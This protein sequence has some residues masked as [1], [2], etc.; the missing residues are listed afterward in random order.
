MATGSGIIRKVSGK[1][2][3]L[4][5][6][7]QNGQQVIAAYNPH[8]KNPQ[9]TLQMQQRTKWLNVLAMYK[10]MKPYLK[11]AF[12]NK[13]SGQ[14]D[15][16]RFMGINLQAVPVYLTRA[17]FV[18]GGAIIAPYLIAQ[19]SLPA[20]TMTGNTTDIVANFTDAATVAEASASILSGDARFKQGDALCFFVVA[21]SVSAEGTPVAQAYAMKLPLDLT[22][23]T[24]LSSLYTAQLGIVATDGL[25]SVTTNSEVYAT[26][27]VHTRRTEKLLVSSARLQVT[28]DINTLLSDST[29]AASANS[30]GYTEGDIFLEPDSTVPVTSNGSGSTD[31]TEEDDNTGSSGTGNNDSSGEDSNP[32]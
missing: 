29:F 25:V 21:Q 32:L 23:T 6:R 7:V 8:V 4:V 10:V 18:D 31:D 9:T 19:G 26:A 1:V 5:Y 22:D 24:P 15:Y 3:D 13:P 17:Q 11:G 30:L 12:E 27:V 2:G 16:N 28:G 14:N 20:I